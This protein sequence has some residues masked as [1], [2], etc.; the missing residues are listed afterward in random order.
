MGTL[1]HMSKLKKKSSTCF[2]PLL[3]T[4]PLQETSKWNHPRFVTYTA[5][6]PTRLQK[7]YLASPT[8]LLLILKL[9]C[10]KGSHEAAEAQI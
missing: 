9:F 2:L 3:S 5:T 4:D 6:G 1:A 8:I 10:Q 7:H